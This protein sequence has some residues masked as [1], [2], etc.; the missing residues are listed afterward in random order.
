[1]PQNRGCCALPLTAHGGKAKRIEV[2]K[3]PCSNSASSNLFKSCRERTEAHLMSPPWD[4]D[5]AITYQNS[6]YTAAR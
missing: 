1:M 5:E 6:G 2:L 4:T 3:P